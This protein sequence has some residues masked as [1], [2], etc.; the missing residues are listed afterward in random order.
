MHLSTYTPATDDLY[1]YDGTNSGWPTG[2]NPSHPL[3]AYRSQLAWV[4]VRQRS[5][6]L[7]QSGSDITYTWNANDGADETLAQKPNWFNPRLPAL[8]FVAPRLA[9]GAMHFWDGGLT[10][11]ARPASLGLWSTPVIRTM[12]ADG[13]LRTFAN[14]Q[15]RGT[16]N[17]SPLGTWRGNRDCGYA[18]LEGG[19]PHPGPFPTILR[20]DRPFDDVTVWLIEGNGRA[21]QFT[22]NSPAF[23]RYSGFD[24]PWVVDP[25]VHGYTMDVDPPAQKVAGIEALYNGD[26]GGILVALIDGTVYALGHM[27]Q[28]TNLQ[29]PWA[30]TMGDPD[31]AYLESLGHTVSVRSFGIDYPFG[32]EASLAAVQAKIDDINDLLGVP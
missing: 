28:S 6:S 16:W 31:L 13:S 4:G 32:L 23:Y 19:T 11:R 24:I 10:E 20:I 1:T 29:A 14:A 17:Q 27:T 5:T 9:I 12:D 2:W 21:I 15:F 18:E 25:R 22:L 30:N 8:S 7:A 26:S 3:Y